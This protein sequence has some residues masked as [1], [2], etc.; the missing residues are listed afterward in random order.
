MPD[1]A[2][3]LAIW[4]SAALQPGGVR[5]AALL[6]ERPR[7]LSERNHL[8]LRRHVEFFGGRLELIGRCPQCTTEVEF[9]VDAAQCAKALVHDV[10]L[11]HDDWHTLSA[12]GVATRFRLPRPEDL[13]ALSTIEDAEAFAEAL[14]DRCVDGDRPT[15]PELREA[16]STRMRELMPGATLE[17]AL[18]CPDCAHQWQAP[19]DPADLLWRT[20]RAQA[21]RLLAEIALLARR[22]GWSERDILSLG[23]MRR[24][25]YLQ[26]AGA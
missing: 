22:F 5:D 26:L 1:G 25:A 21:E 2:Q 4:E 17:F 12:A 23:P 19:L 7:S 8:A 24:A 13:H 16:L 15:E 9:T 6:G 18:Q 3:L 20:L 10:E 11:D 14:L